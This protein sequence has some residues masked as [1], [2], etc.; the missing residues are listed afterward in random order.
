[1]ASKLKDQ[2]EANVIWNWDY[3]GVYGIP[4]FQAMLKASN[5][6][7]FNEQILEE[8]SKIFNSE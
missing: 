5:L 1:M 3:L 8:I 2:L 4:K 7:N 6:K